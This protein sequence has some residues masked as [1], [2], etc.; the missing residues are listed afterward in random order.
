MSRKQ[1]GSRGKT[2]SVQLMKDED[3]AIRRVVEEENRSLAEYIRMLILADLKQRAGQ[4]PASVAMS[5]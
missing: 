5:A 3:R 4:A 1:K 2:I